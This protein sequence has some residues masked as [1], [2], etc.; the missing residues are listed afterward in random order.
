[1]ANTETATTCNGMK[2]VKPDYE[3]YETN[4]SIKTAELC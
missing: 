1:M 4:L 3:N 2:T